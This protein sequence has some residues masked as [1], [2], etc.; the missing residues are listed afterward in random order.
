M[1]TTF[2]AVVAVIL[3][4]LPANANTIT[5]GSDANQFDMEFVPIGN[6]GNP[7]DTTG[8]PNPAGSVPYVYQ[9]GKYEVS[10][11][12]VTKANVEGNLGLIWDE[13]DYIPGGPRLDL[14][15]T[16]TN[17]NYAARFVNWLN[18]SQGHQKAYKF[19]SQP[20]DVGYNPAEDILLWQAGDPGF[21]AANPFRN[22]LAQYA[23]PS[24]H[25]WQ[26]AAYY[27]PSSNQYFNFPTGS[28]SAPDPVASG[29]APGTAV[30]AQA[31]EQG[32]ADIT[33]AGGLSPYGVMGLGGNAVEWEET[34]FDLANDDGSFPRGI[35]SGSWNG[36]SMELSASFREGIG[37]SFMGYG[38]GVGFRVVSIPEPSSLVLGVLGCLSV[39]GVV[40]RRGRSSTKLAALFLTMITVPSAHSQEMIFPGEQWTRATPESQRVES[41]RL[42][43][44]ADFLATNTPGTIGANELVIIRN[45]RLIWDGS[46]ADRAHEVYSVTKSFTSTI[47]GLLIEDGVVS[48]DT[49]VADYFPALEDSYSDLTLQHL[50]SMTSPYRAVGESSSPGGLTDTLWVP[51]APVFGPPGDRVVLFERNFRS[52]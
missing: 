17:W 10:R 42:D 19:A 6:P 11:D 18:V 36:S 4:S 20:G 13:N 16:V 1:K 41:T 31:F 33:Q 15:A 39:A 46:N 9:I 12:M 45:G 7:A 25:E 51:D 49:R 34:E 35:R 32:P 37:P 29:T 2:F 24:V 52:S 14:P 28:D 47:L 43:K 30:Y 21:D 23:L 22:S 40:G 27:D 48:L 3:W 38:I 8:V 26:K 50:V 44:A 5:F